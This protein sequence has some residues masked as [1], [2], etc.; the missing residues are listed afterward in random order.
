M[1]PITDAEIREARGQRRIRSSLRMV[2]AS[3]LILLR[4]TEMLRISRLALPTARRPAKSWKEVRA[5]MLGLS[6]QS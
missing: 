2:L 5:Q 6:T 4:S 1:L 3:R